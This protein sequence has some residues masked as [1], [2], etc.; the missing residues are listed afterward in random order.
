MCSSDLEGL[1]PERTRCRQRPGLGQVAMAG[2]ADA[3]VQLLTTLKAAG[4]PSTDD[5]RMIHGTS[6]RDVCAM[7]GRREE[8]RG[9]NGKTGSPQDSGGY[10]HGG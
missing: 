10:I 2:D 6:G 1:L 8:D 9:K 5:A 4:I 3:I 7:G